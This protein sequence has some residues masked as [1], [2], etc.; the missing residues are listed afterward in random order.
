MLKS[1]TIKNYA[2]IRHLQINFDHGFTAV[3]GET[4]AGKSIILGAM[5]LMLGQRADSSMFQ[6]IDEKCITEGVFEISG[7]Q[8]QSLFEEEELDYWDETILRREILP[9]GKSRA[10]INDTPVN[11]QQLKRIASQ[12]IDIHSQ[13]QTSEINDLGFQQEVIDAYAKLS[14]DKQAYV[15]QFNAYKA[16]QKQ[17]AQLKESAAQAKSEQDFH[18]FQFDQLNEAKLIA[19]EEQELEEEQNLLTHASDIKLALGT[20]SDALNSDENGVVQQLLSA[21][22]EASGATKYMHEMGEIAERI[23]S[24]RIELQDLGNETEQLLENIEFDPARLDFINDRLSLLFSLKQKNQVET[25]DDLIALKQQ[26]ETKLQ[27][28]ENLDEEI[29]TLEQKV[30]NAMSEVNQLAQRLSNKRKKVFPAIE[31]NIRER[32]SLLGM[33]NGLLKIEHTL[34]NEPDKT[35]IDQ[36]VFKF[37]ANKNHPPKP[38]S[39]VA[40]GGEKSR[41][42]LAIKSLLAE[43]KNLPTIIFDEID[44]GISGD[45]AQ[46]LANQLAV[47]ANHMQLLSITHLPQVASKGNNHLKVYKEENKTGTLTSIKKLT[48]EERIMELAE[49]LSGKNPPEAAIL[50]AR[51]LL[52]R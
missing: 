50:N 3:T 34:K 49:M 40:S 22:K 24:A 46:K 17:L 44:T 31:K 28:T 6:N 26:L 5:H 12:L 1:L 2:L 35:G 52:K 19:G 47:L 11:L 27:E 10:F 18:Q 30:A 25:V 4:G 20:I 38:L 21:F 32:V 13:S 42:M 36:I 9:S 23:E 33:P 39:Q 37:S 45:I 48:D 43:H 7:Y 51:E 41:L 14:A 15:S 16:L 8:L 29:R